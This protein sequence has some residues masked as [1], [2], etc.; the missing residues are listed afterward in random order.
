MVHVVDGL[1]VVCVV[2]VVI[3]A[4]GKRPTEVHILW[5]RAHIANGLTTGDNNIVLA[6][7]VS[8][9]VWAGRFLIAIHK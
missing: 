8:H 1:H 6:S 3:V 2:V 5:F 7:P 9:I 4:F